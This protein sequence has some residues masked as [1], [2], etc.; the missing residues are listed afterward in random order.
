MSI[1]LLKHLI[2]WCIFWFIHNTFRFYNT[3][4]YRK[5]HTD[6]CFVA[7]FACPVFYK[8]PCSIFILAVL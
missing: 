7:F 2:E 6:S 5:F 3:V 1:T 8:F 4:K